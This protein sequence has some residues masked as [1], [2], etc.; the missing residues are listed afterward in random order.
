MLGRGPGDRVV[1]AD[2]DVLVEIAAEAI[3]EGEV[4]AK[5]R[6]DPVAVYVAGA[7]VDAVEFAARRLEH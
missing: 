2:A 3:G 4:E 5:P 6:T 7:A 1:L